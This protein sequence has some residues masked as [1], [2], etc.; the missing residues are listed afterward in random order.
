MIMPTETVYGL[1]ARAADPAAVARLF[2]AKGRPRFNPLIAHV[3]DVARAR[4]IAVLD[5]RAEALIAAFWPGPLTPS[6]RRIGRD[7][8]CAISRSRPG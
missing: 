2:E 6:S 5:E 8:P 7:P 3:S 4:E 1:A